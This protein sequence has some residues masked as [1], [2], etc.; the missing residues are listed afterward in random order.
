MAA[1]LNRSAGSPGEA[2]KI[3]I[4]SRGDQIPRAFAC[5]QAHS[6]ATGFA[7]APPEDAVA[8]AADPAKDE[9]KDEKKDK[10]KDV[11][12]DDALSAEDARVWAACAGP[13]VFTDFSRVPS[14][15]EW[16]SGRNS[17]GTRSPCLSLRAT[18]S[19]RFAAARPKCVDVNG[20]KKLKIEPS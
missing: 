11:K 18:V 1:T 2:P 19:M 8:I 6:R 14:R 5:S 15:G 17:S 3:S 7:M 16:F 4:E 20:G 13:C 12:D 10:S 9:K